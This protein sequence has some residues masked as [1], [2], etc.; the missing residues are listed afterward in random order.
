MRFLPDHSQIISRR[1]RGKVSVNYNYIIDT[2]KKLFPDKAGKDLVCL[3]FGCG[4]GQVVAHGLQAGFDY[5]GAD[6]YPES[7]S[8]HYEAAAGENKIL[9]NHIYKIENDLLPF[10]DNHFDFVSSNVVF[11]HIANIEKPLSEINRVLKPGGY[12]LC[13]FPT[14]ETW[15]EG[16]V[17]LY[18]AHWLNPPSRVCHL[19][20]KAMKS[21]GLGLKANDESPEKWAEHYKHYLNQ[22]CFYRPISEV[23][24]S[25]RAAFQGIPED[26][27]EN[28]M[29]YRLS[30]HKTLKKAIPVFS[31][32]VGRFILRQ[33][34]T[35]RAGRVL[36][37]RKMN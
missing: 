33:A 32:F 7:R 1:R 27:A 36:L 23:L 16:H 26:W 28:Y 17:K 24:D 19:Y 37:T 14:K 11:E 15:W 18:F 6:P 22:Y 12:F 8:E 21:L 5:R 25:W 2:I 3:D 31:N 13:L 29:L 10:P 35:I 34:C 30:H 4:A 9:K 20:L